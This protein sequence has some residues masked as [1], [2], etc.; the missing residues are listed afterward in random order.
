M[1]EIACFF[2][3]RAR[4]HNRG[5]IEMFECNLKLEHLNVMIKMIEMK[6]KLENSNAKLN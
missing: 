2:G 4:V 6:I 3:G 1:I 5:L